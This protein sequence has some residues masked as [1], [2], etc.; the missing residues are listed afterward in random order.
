[1]KAITP[2]IA[3]IMLLLLTISIIGIAF[4]FFTR[5]VES[6]GEEASGITE[7]QLRQLG[8]DLRIDSAA[9]D[10]VYIRNTG[11]VA[12]P[13]TSL[14]FYINDQKVSAYSQVASIEPGQIAEFTIDAPLGVYELTV[15]GGKK[16][17]GR[18]VTPTATTTT[19]LPGQTTTT[20]TT[21]PAGPQTITLTPGFD[22]YRRSIDNTCDDS[23]TFL[24]V[25]VGYLSPGS[26]NRAYIKFPLTNLPG[27][28][29]ISDVKLEV[30]VTG[31]GFA[32]GTSPVDIQAYNQDGQADPQVD[33]CATRW[34]RTANDPTP[35]V[36]N[37][38]TV[39]SSTGPKTIQLPP[40]ANTDIENAKI[41]VNPFTIAINEDNSN[42]FGGIASSEGGNPPKLIITYVIPPTTT[43]TTTLPGTTTTISATTTTTTSSTTT[44]T[45]PTVTLIIDEQVAAGADDVKI[46]PNLFLSGSTFGVTGRA[47]GGNYEQA[48]RF[49]TVDIPQG[50]IIDVAH[51][52]VNVDTRSCSTGQL[53]SAIYGENRD[54]AAQITSNPDFLNRPLTA[55]VD[56]D[57]TSAWACD[58]TWK[59]SPSIVSV[60]Q[61]IVN[62]PGWTSGNTINIF[63]KADTT[64]DGNWRRVRHFES[65]AANAPK[66]HVEYHT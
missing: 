19:T 64:L 10:K 3:V 15:T 55:K 14:G 11:S 12:I 46:W 60:L 54:N 6:T 23:A 20:T 53:I 35:Y 2:V 56:W 24:A 66:L 9:G 26:I 65:G 29:E 49:T 47:N 36:N 32:G 61:E 42:D 43:T 27:N 22:G 38:A 4:L 37:D 18:V 39:F 28:A 57:D 51:V 7:Q 45:L 31:T 30:S 8:T 5:L 44:S 63:W 33:S 34:I 58:G 25:G 21:L 59:M 40:A 48:L 50:A 52:E 13:N 1:M 41:A 16:A 17:V 62:R